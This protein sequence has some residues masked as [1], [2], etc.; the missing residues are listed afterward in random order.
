MPRAARYLG[1]LGDIHTEED[2]LAAAL[3]L[4]S[5]RGAEVIVSVGDI[6]DGPGDVARCLQRL[7]EAGVLAVAGN[8]ER[9]LLAGQMRELPE[10][11]RREDL[12][13]EALDILR[14]LPALR[15]IA[16]SCGEAML[17]HG[18][19]RDDMA[20]VRPDD[21]GYGLANNT[22]LTAAEDLL[23][24]RGA[25]RIINGHTHRA[26]VRQVGATTIFNAG[27]LYRAH[28]PGCLWLDCEAQRATFISL[29]DWRHP[30]PAWERAW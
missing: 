8:H 6:V 2:R 7:R 14:A 1:V 16:T 24:A 29:D 17:C 22:A 10:A 25:S 26:M 3:D 11:H 9:W 12:S 30:C 18:L 4:F 28:Q 5:A 15:W 13:A 23:A 21:F 27:T 20:G 19:G